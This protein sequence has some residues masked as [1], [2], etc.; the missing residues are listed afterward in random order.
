MLPFLNWDWTENP[1]EA[2]LVIFSKDNPEDEPK[3]VKT[4]RFVLGDGV[5]HT[6]PSL[7]KIEM[8]NTLKY[9]KN[10]YNCDIAEEGLAFE[11]HVIENPEQ[12]EVT[13]TSRILNFKINALKFP[14]PSQD[15]NTLGGEH[16][17]PPPPP[18]KKPFNIFANF[19]TRRAGL[20]PNQAKKKNLLEN[21]PPPPPLS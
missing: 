12:C 4:K 11:T 21:I 18:K 1:N 9:I 13:H 6:G 14:E 10:K 19:S 17:F 5:F 3:D 7:S 2:D 15:F 20:F 16:G 8:D